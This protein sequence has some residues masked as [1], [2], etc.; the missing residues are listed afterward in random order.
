MIK[1]K[2]KYVVLLGIIALGFP[3]CLKDNAFLNVANTQ[4]IAEFS[5]AA[6]TSS[7]Y[8][9]GA[10]PDTSVVDT[11]IAVDIASPQ[12]LSSDVTI[13]VSW[14]TTLIAAYNT[15]NSQFPLHPLPDSCFNIAMPI[16]VKIPAGYRIGRIPVKLF[17]QKINPTV[18]YAMPLRITAATGTGASILVSGNAGTLMYAF[19]GNPIAGA[20]TQEYIRYNTATQTGTP[21]ADQITPGALFT[22]VTPI[23]VTATSGIGVTYDITFTSTNGVPNPGSFAVSLVSSSVSAVGITISAGPTIVTADPVNGK[24][25]FNFQYINASGNSR[26]ITDIFTK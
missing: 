7:S 9:W 4:A 24:F 17:P 23:E 10:L 3:S 14:D 12:V 16:S 19:I 25:Q 18:S 13:T 20:Y 26:N 11:A 2:F 8:S 6:P 15:A 1:N 5:I 21:V 22:P